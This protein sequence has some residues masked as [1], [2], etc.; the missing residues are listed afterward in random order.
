MV[1]QHLSETVKK[2]DDL[3]QHFLNIEDRNKVDHLVRFYL[4]AQIK[5]A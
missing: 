4:K 2:V 5:Q 1:A 3:L